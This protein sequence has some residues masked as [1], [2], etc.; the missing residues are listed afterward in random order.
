MIWLVGRGGMLGG[1][2]EKIL[3]ALGRAYTAS[4]VEVDFTSLE[5]VREFA[6]RHEPDWV[7]NC[8]AYTAVDRAEDE[9]EAAERLNVLGP[10]NLARV[11]VERGAGLL[12]IST[13]YVFDG[14]KDGP[15]TEGDSP[16]PIGVYARTKAEGERRIAALLPRHL[17]CRTAWLFGAGGKNFVSTMLRLFRERSRLSVVADQRGR[18]TYA[19]DLAAALVALLD[20]AA[21][22]AT[23]WGVYH[24]ANA[25]ETTWFEFAR[26]ILREAGGRGL[27]DGKCL[28]SPVTSGEYPT[29]AHRPANSVLSTARIEQVAGVR[30]RPWQE[31]LGDYLS[32]VEPQ[33]GAGGG[34][35]S[36]GRRG[37]RI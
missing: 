24:F 28:I 30:P 13:D 2:V 6:A 15:Y 22:A 27:T 8:A 37:S 23:P 35:D 4:D 19:P 21:G 5:T 26:E 18:P 29:R 1:E 10:E 16:N 34:A 25:G 32:E 7:I 36:S 14:A 3:R 20:A 11:C 33:V 12:H 17:I 9:P 31:A